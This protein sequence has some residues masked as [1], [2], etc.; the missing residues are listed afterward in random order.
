M[1]KRV[2]TLR[3]SIQSFSLTFLL[4]VVLFLA[5]AAVLSLTAGVFW[6]GISMGWLP[7]EQLMMPGPVA[8]FLFGLCALIVIGV[9]AIL[10]ALVLRP[11][12][13]MI[14]DMKRLAA[15]D[16]SVRISNQGRMRPRELREFTAAFNTAAEELGGT[17]ILRK[18]FINNF[19]HEFK[20]PITSIGGFADLI[21]EDDEMPDE[22][23][24]E[25]LQIISKEAHRLANLATNVLALSRIEAQT[26]LTDTE[27]FNLTEQ[28]RQ[29]VLMMEQKWASKELEIRLDAD[30]CQYT[31]NEAL[32]KEVWINLLDNAIKFSPSEGE[33]ELTLRQ[34][35]QGVEVTV[36]DYGSGMDKS[37]QSHIFDQFY[38]GDT[39]HKTEG[40]GLGLAM[41]KKIVVLHGGT[42]TVVST[43]ELGSTFIT[44]LP[45][46]GV[47]RSK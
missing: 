16:F 19:S 30:E 10:R 20:T 11:I 42:V 8:A 45:A 2:Q 23:C 43:P 44:K 15:G 31:G 39:S 3:D 38:Q 27:R 1:K 4:T 28:L 33:V 17:E 6:L 29:V 12:R 41:V 21:L 24:Q 14:D 13:H 9:M 25:Y 47:S 46:G 22:E 40:N 26:I 37:V 18:D 5:V 7:F 36:R 34:T 35:G 32:L